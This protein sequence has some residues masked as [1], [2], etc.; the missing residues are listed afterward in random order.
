MIFPNKQKAEAKY[1]MD[2]M[3]AT[4]YWNLITKNQAR[5]IHYIIQNQEWK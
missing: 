4:N 3:S 5:G 1:I 2:Q